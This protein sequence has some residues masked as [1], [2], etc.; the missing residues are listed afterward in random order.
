M[1][2]E[3]NK[4]DGN[5]VNLGGNGYGLDG[6]RGNRRYWECSDLLNL[7]INFKVNPLC[8]DHEMRE[9]RVKV[10][11]SVGVWAGGKET[12]ILIKFK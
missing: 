1:G 10:S 6:D 3:G 5:G 11:S 8:R 2:S 9:R 7:K 12:W 4:P